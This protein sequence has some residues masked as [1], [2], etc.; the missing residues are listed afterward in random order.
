MKSQR[1]IGFLIAVLCLSAI[2]HTASAQNF[3]DTLM[4]FHS[5]LCEAINPAQSQR[6]QWRET[7]L[8]NRDPNFTQDS[9]FGVVAS[10]QSNQPVQ[11]TCILR[12]SEA[13]TI[14]SESQTFSMSP[15]GGRAEF[16]WEVYNTQ[17]V[18]PVV[19]CNLPP[20]VSV[21]GLLAG[22]AVFQ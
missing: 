5:S 4:S 13:Q 6:M 17:L 21:I 2:P 15:N 22:A 10:N 16:Y 8:I 19:Q 18:G 1:L 11:L 7:G 3:S 14:R 20:N 12:Y 9:F